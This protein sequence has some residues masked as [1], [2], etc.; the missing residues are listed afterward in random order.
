[1]SVCSIF[2][3]ASFRTRRSMRPRSIS[4]TFMPSRSLTVAS[5][6]A[7]KSYTLPQTSGTPRFTFSS[8]EHGLHAGTHGVFRRE[9]G[10][11]LRF[12][13]LTEE[14]EVHSARR[15]NVRAVAVCARHEECGDI[16]HHAR[17]GVGARLRKLFNLILRYTDVIQPFHADLLA[18]AL[19]HRLFDVIAG[20]VGEQAIDPMGRG[21]RL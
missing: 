10:V 14:R 5:S 18:G 16:R 4:V 9:N 15:H 13:E 6:S 20:L 1:M 7:R 2:F 17:H 12:G 11:A 19:A 8:W 3:S 21:P